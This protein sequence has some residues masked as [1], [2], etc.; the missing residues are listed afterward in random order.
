MSPKLR[1]VPCFWICCISDRIRAGIA[2]E[3]SKERAM[4][5]LVYAREHGNVQMADNV[6]NRPGF[7]C[8]CCSCCCEMMEAFRTLPEMTRVISSSYLAEI[9]AE[10]CSGCG[11]CATL[12]VQASM[13]FG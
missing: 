8:N 10:N 4:D 2:K 11:K 6:R 1:T 5:V 12:A 13:S 9:D 7:I 3:I